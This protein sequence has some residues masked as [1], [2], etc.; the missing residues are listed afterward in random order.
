MVAERDYCA[1]GGHRARKPRAAATM[2]IMAPLAERPEAAPG[3][4]EVVGAGGEPE[5]APELVG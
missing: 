5:L 2:A 3:K 4:S 1:L